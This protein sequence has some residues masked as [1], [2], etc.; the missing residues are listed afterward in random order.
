MFPELSPGGGGFLV[1][2]GVLGG[3]LQ[4][5]GGHPPL[6]RG[7]GGGGGQVDEVASGTRVDN[8]RV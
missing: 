1:E 6:G 5:V 2:G 4:H 7:G 3:V 8:L